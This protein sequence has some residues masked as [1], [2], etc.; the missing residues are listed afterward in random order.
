MVGCQNFRPDTLLAKTLL[1][2]IDRTMVLFLSAEAALVPE[3]PVKKPVKLLALNYNY[4]DSEGEDEE[5]REKR[6]AKL[7]SATT[8]MFP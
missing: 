6:K 2:V 5:T 7:V 4:T 3:V 8:L 1:L